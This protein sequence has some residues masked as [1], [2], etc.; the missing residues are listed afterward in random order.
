[1]RTCNYCHR[2]KGIQENATVCPYCGFILNDFSPDCEETSDSIGELKDLERRYGMI[3]FRKSKGNIILV[4]I[5]LL[6]LCIIE[7]FIK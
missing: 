4:V 1:M 6:L 3:N 5:L 7:V 2:Q